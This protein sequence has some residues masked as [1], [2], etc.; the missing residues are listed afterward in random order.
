MPDALWIVKSATV[1]EDP[2]NEGVAL[3]Q[4]VLEASARAGDDAHVAG[5]CPQ[6]PR[7][8]H[9]IVLIVARA[10]SSR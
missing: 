7:T 2:T 3:R 10:T 5:K 6:G 1:P 4:P 8:D 9:V